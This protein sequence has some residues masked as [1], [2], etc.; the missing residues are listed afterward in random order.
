MASG[1]TF[2][3]AVCSIAWDESACKA[4]T[5]DH[6]PHTY[7]HHLVRCYD[8]LEEEEV[9][10]PTMEERMAAIEWS[11]GSLHQRF[12]RVERLLERIEHKL[13]TDTENVNNPSRDESNLKE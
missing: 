9:E 11:V 12:E 8:R 10:G 3:C 5:K 13:L 1:D 7:V 6:K 4:F 2:Q